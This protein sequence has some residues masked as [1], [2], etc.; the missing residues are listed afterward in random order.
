M[1]RNPF[2]RRCLQI[3]NHMTTYPYQIIRRP[4]RK[5]LAISIS[6]DC[7][8]RILAPARLH[9]HEIAELVRQKSGWIEEKITLLNERQKQLRCKQYISGEVFRY[10]GK[11][12][13][14]HILNN[15][16]IQAAKLKNGRFQVSLPKDMPM[17]IQQQTIIDLL[18][19][20]Y[21][22][23]ALARMTRETKRLAKHISKVPKSVGIKDYTSRWGSCHPDG[24]IY[25]N[26][27]LIMAPPTISEYVVVHELCHLIHGNHSKKFWNLVTPILPDYKE[28]RKWLRLNGFNLTV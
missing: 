3:S 17:Q 4:R 2:Y 20:W 18:T 5:T 13:P 9:E 28:R 23:H 1:A 22:K 11:N 7:S 8:V 21:K 27:R 12:Y 6:P 10:L 24:R 16:D 19:T 26:W 15:N 25:F 14:L